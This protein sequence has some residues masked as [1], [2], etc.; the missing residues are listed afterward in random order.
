MRLHATRIV[1][2]TGKVNL[3]LADEKTLCTV[4]G[5]G[6]LLAKNIL[7]HRE[8]CGKFIS[9]Q[10]LNDVPQIGSRIYAQ[11]HSKFFVVPLSKKSSGSNS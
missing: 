7:A 8:K 2:L 10:Q 1:S 3:N 6:P 5:I 11:V 4:P 9:L